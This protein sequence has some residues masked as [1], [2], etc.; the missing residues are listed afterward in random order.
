MYLFR[1]L[2]VDDEP[3]I[4]DEVTSLLEAQQTMNLDVCFAYRGADALQIIQE[5]RID[6][7]ITDIQMPQISGLTLMQHICE[8]WP[9]CKMIVLTGHSNFGYAY[10]SMKYNAFAYI[11]KTEPDHVLLEEVQKAIEANKEEMRLSAD[12]SFLPVLDDEHT[13]DENNQSLLLYALNTTPL[14]KA[15]YYQLKRLLAFY[16]SNNIRHIKLITL[17]DCSI[18]VILKL[19]MDRKNVSAFL[20]SVLERTQ[21]AFCERTTHSLSL[22][23][24]LLT[25][26]DDHI[27]DIV[28]RLQTELSMT[29]PAIPI[30]TIV[31]AVVDEGR[32]N[33]VRFL[34]NYIHAHVRDNL[35]LMQLSTLSGYSADYLSKVFRQ[36]TGITI[37]RYI[38]SQR[39]AEIENLMRNQALTLEEISR[40]AGFHSRAYFNH[41]F[42]N[43]TGMAPKNYQRKLLQ[44]Q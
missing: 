28:S 21:T 36:E 8:Q 16:F 40:L 29:N 38:A 6:L 30:V 9:E 17:E 31:P 33:I 20:H 4:V 12:T 44:S 32:Y 22:A 3:A 11:L 19:K 25:A 5:G 37:S 43:E 34:K 39:L 14:S 13:Q 41:F 1:V 18:A 42:K 27:T 2:V 23:A 15:D 24:M 7:L 35:S 26:G 10:E